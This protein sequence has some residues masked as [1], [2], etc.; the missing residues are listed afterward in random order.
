MMEALHSSETSVITNATGCN[1]L[2]EGI[3]Q[4][5]LF[6][7]QANLPS[8]EEYLNVGQD[9]VRKRRSRI[10]SNHCVAN[11]R[12]PILCYYVA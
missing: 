3:L 1:I 2:E 9:N 7:F 4:F 10:V 8:A 5:F 12:I 6:C 11:L